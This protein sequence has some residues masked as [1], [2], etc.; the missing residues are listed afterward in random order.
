[1]IRG[2][3]GKQTFSIGFR[4]VVNRAFSSNVMAAMLV[5]SQQKNFDSFFC[6]GN[7]HGHNAFC[8]SWDCVKTLCFRCCF[9]IY[10]L[11]FYHLVE[12]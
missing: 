7:K 12:K 4:L 6:F 11:F 2:K 3:K 10:R 8:I 5:C 1:M 9:A